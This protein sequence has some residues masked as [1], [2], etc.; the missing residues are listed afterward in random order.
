M[1]ARATTRSSLKT[2]QKQLQ[3]QQEVLSPLSSA[4]PAAAA[5]GG[6]PG[7]QDSRHAAAAAVQQ[8]KARSAVLDGRQKALKVTANALYGFTGAQASPLQCAPLADSCLALGAATCRSAAAA[9]GEALDKGLL[10]SK[11][12]GGKVGSRITVPT[13]D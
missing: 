10:G 5:V 1:S 12:Q 9:I 2:V 13:Y 11:G 8:L 4:T 7:H 3:Q 6:L